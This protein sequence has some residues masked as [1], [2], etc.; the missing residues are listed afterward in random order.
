ME[1][2]S[3]LVIEIMQWAEIKEVTFWSDSVRQ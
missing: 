2:V 1:N 3:M